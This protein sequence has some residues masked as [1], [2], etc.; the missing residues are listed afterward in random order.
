MH[1]G[2][3]EKSEIRTYLASGVFRSV[4]EGEAGNSGARDGSGLGLKGRCGN[5]GAGAGSGLGLIGGGG[6]KELLRPGFGSFDKAFWAGVETF[7]GVGS[8]RFV[9]DSMDWDCFGGK[10]RALVSFS[11]GS[12]T[13]DAFALDAGDF[14]CCFES[15]RGRPPTGFDD[16]DLGEDGEAFSGIL[17]NRLKELCCVSDLR[18]GSERDDSLG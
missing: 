16:T 15:D 18:L 8:D 12:F 4:I 9:L 14:D 7:L 5:S 2:N 13:K 6:L 3:T 10:F 1:V 17:S 11:L